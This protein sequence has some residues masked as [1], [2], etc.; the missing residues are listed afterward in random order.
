MEEYSWVAD[1]YASEGYFDK[2]IAM[3]TKASKMAPME[4]S[5]QL[6][7]QRVQ[8]M[9]KVRAASDQGHAITVGSGWA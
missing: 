1:R 7:M 5:L 6:K 9:R 4:S 3:L 2:S 8:R